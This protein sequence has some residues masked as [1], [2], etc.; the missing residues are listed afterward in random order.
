MALLKSDRMG[1]QSRSRAVPLLWL[2]LAGAC[3]AASS[4]APAPKAASPQAVAS[5]RPRPSGANGA[6]PGNPLAAPLVTTKGIVGREESAIDARFSEY[7]GRYRDAT[8]SKVLEELDIKGS[9]DA[10]LPFDPT[11]V[12]Y[13][14]RIS[15][16]LQLT[17][18]ERDIYRRTGVV[19]VDHVQR[20]SMGS[21]YFAIY[22]RDLPVLVTTDSI[23]H[24]LHRSY[25]AVLEQM[26]MAI[27]I[28]LLTE[29]LQAAHD[30]LE[31][32]AGELASKLLADSAADVDVYLTV[33]QDLLR[34]HGAAAQ[35]NAAPHPAPEPEAVSRFGQESKV[36]E[37]LGHVA[38]LKLQRPDAPTELNGGRRAI[39]YSQ[40]R[41]RGHYAKG[42]LL[43]RYFRAM[44]WLGRADTA[45]LVAPPDPRSGL[46]V[47]AQREARSAALLT[48]TLHE[49]G[50]LATLGQLS[51]IIDF[52]VGRADNVTLEDMRAALGR[53]GVAA[54]AD[55]ADDAR[56]QKLRTNVAGLGAQRIRS[57]VITSN[58][59]DPVPVPPPQV[60]QVFGQRFV[61]DSFA[62]SK[63]VFDEI[64]F[65]GAK[66]ERMMPR[67]FDVMAVLG[68]DEAVRLLK[69]DVEQHHYG[70]N[71]LALRKT[72][73]ERAETSWQADLYGSW[74]DA[75]R[76]L[77]DVPA[78]H[79][80]A[81]MSR[82]P[83]RRKQLQTQLAS[84][85]ELRHD[86]LLY[87]KQ[88][89]TAWP[90]CGY[91]E[92]FVEPYPE[93]YD[94]MHKL[95]T[96]AADLFA[97]IKLSAS[98]DQVGKHAQQLQRNQVAF[99]QRFAEVM[100]FLAHLARKELAAQ[101]FSQDE[102]TFLKRTINVTGGG[103]GPPTYDGWYPRL[104]YGG[105]S[106]KWKPSIA[107]VH[108]N[109][110]GG[111]V[112]EVGVGDVNYL[113]VAV[114]NQ[115]DRA[116]YVGPV[117]SYYEFEKPVSER[118]T[119]EE[120]EQAITQ[121]NLP[122]RPAFSEVFRAKPESRQMGYVR[123]SGRPEEKRISELYEQFS[124]E[125]NAAR[126]NQL[127]D[128]IQKLRRELGENLKKER[129]SPPP[130]PRKQQPKP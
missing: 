86:T 26:E 40:F 83:W 97:G 57:Q 3:T 10:K 18:A 41:P 19:S 91:P 64:E 76:E 49:S 84:W 94:R 11:T 61:I 116:A 108:T 103:S 50:A 122:P 2:L 17:A 28:P 87:A 73:D 14:D 53:V 68:N 16:E 70:P 100:E 12:R 63:V 13:F 71:L 1:V 118:M 46:E 55:L 23:L 90:T 42:E 72:I 54:V 33:A 79:F 75:V 128:Q 66:P 9:A 117:Y 74:L 59:T 31:K 21:V 67:G 110:A 35:S 8:Y 127:R 92:G 48:L 39:D 81:V 111:R 77:D 101:P 7:R 121:N 120:W 93:F 47:N 34:G 24:A 115:G 51:R 32:H 88:S 37:I 106:D 124:K 102:Q 5:A 52:M 129:V 36:K 43:K 123:S 62:L 98:S 109:P 126:R 4:T 104:V 130:S 27:F 85:A 78:G 6:S 119:D 56:L 89:Y 65:N 107:D 95:A 114:D 25:D 29:A 99:F 96:R 112:L 30:T 69:P 44:M 80:P 105:A 125:T 58:P 15:S 45:F 20:Y 38:S 60:F 113:V 82:E 22:A